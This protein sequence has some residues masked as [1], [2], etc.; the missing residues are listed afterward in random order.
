M[1]SIREWFLEFVWVIV[2]CLPGALWAN[3]DF[4]AAARKGDVAVLRA[5]L[6]KGLDVNTK[7]RYDQT[8]LLIAASRGHV[9]AVKLLLER[10]AAVDIKD[11]FYGVTPLGG[12]MGFGSPVQESK[13]AA[14]AVLLIQK[15]A[16]DKD[17]L[18]MQ[19]ARTGKKEVVKAVLPAAQWTPQ[20]LTSALSAAVAGKQPEVEAM[21]KAAGAIPK[22]EVKLDAAVLARYAGSYVNENKVELKVEVADGKLRASFG[23]GPMSALLALD[24]TSFEVEQAPGQKIVFIANGESVSGVEI[25]A[26][27]R[28]MKFTKVAAK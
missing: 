28:T 26:G 19:A 1:K 6:D 7:W 12:A 9:E 3:E 15:G 8:A 16:P 4:F 24:S 5:H 2:L 25:Q 10:G 27:S 21:L 14:I 13:S 17:R 11:S 23:G 22:V 18:L 20:A